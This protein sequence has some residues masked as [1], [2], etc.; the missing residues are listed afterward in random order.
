MRL[1]IFIN[2]EPFYKKGAT[3][4]I[5]ILNKLNI[6][7]EVCSKDSNYDI[8]IVNG[9]DGTVFKVAKEYPD[10]AL[11]PIKRL[12]FP[13]SIALEKIKNGD[14]VIE[15]LMR[16]EVKYKNFR[17]WGIND[18]SVLR[19]DESANRFRVFINGKDAFGDELIG[20]GVVIATPHGSTAYN[21]TAGGQILRENEKRFIVTP[22]CSVYSSKR[23]LM[24]NRKVM[25]RIEKS[26]IIQDNGEVVI[27]FSRNIKNKIVPDGRKEERFYADIKD[28]DKVIIKKAR[29]YSKFV[30]IL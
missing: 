14:Y 16:L 22:I 7:F 6:N 19:D 10:A 8:L 13:V 26:K 24:K 4:I 20:D 27:K 11:L 3:K 17:A 30:K 12:G 9:G 23:V 1:G 25:K 15:K 29:E 18:I 28:G 5:K 2:N 21:W